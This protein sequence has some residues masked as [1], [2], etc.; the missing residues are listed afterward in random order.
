MKRLLSFDELKSK[1]ALSR[2]SIW[3]LERQG[4]FPERRKISTN[5]VGWIEQEVDQWIE[6]RTHVRTSPE[7]VIGGGK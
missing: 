6:A 2:S 7:K 3:R 1:V 4:K 5:R